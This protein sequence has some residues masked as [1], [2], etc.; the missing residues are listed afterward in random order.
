MICSEDGKET[1]EI[2]QSIGRSS[3]YLEAVKQDIVYPDDVLEGLTETDSEEGIFASAKTYACGDSEAV[4]EAY[5]EALLESGFIELQQYP[6]GFAVY[7]IEDPSEYTV[8]EEEEMF[9]LVICA[10]NAPEGI[11]V[12][13]TL[14]DENWDPVQE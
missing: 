6:E 11:T 14:V 4:K 1:L 7:K 10:E 13:A 9:Y 12:T 2:W 5:Y 8:D 3:E